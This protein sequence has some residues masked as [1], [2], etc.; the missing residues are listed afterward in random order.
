MART[1]NF[2]QDHI[3]QPFVV[4]DRKAIPSFS[5]V[6]SLSAKDRVNFFSDSQGIYQQ[7]NISSIYYGNDVARALA[8]GYKYCVGVRVSIPDIR[9]T[10]ISFKATASV[11]SPSK[12]VVVSGHFSVAG[13]STASFQVVDRAWSYSQ[14]GPH[15]SYNDTVLVD[16]FDETGSYILYCAVSNFSDESQVALLSFSASFWTSADNL[17]KV[18]D[19]NAF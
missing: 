11:I 14:P 2:S 8:S 13:S 16:S 10:L 12:D 7:N 4:A 6:T 9:G 18:N 5:N 15:F 17:P 1:L 3:V 19:S